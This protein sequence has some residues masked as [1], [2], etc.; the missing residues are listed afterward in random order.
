MTSVIYTIPGLGFTSAIFSKLNINKYEVHHLEWQLPK[1]EETLNQYAKRFAAQ[2]DWNR[3]VM[4]IGQ[5]FGGILAQEIASMFPVQKIILLSSIQHKQ[6]LPMRLKMLTTIQLHKYINTNLI[7]ATFPFWK[8]THGYH[9]PEEQELFT[10]MVNLQNNDYLKWAVKQISNWQ[11]PSKFNVPI[12][13][14]HGDKDKTFPIELLVKPNYI[15][16]GAMHLMA[17]NRAQ[18]VSEIINAHL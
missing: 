18:E 11:G 1:K 16:S 2:I 4:L 14:I 6:E 9:T 17:F 8:K 7:L 13:Q 3:N 15:I 5:S 10:K 12:V